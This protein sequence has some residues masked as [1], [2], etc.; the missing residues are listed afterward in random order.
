MRM[1]LLQPL[2]GRLRQE[3]PFLSHPERI[4]GRDR[5]S[6]IDST[7][8][9]TILD[10]D[11]APESRIE[12]GAGV[13][14][15]RGVE[16]T[17][18]GG[19]TIAIDDDTSLQDGSIVAGHVQIGAH[20]LFGK[21]VFVA[22]RGHNYRHR[23]EWLIRDQD[24]DAL[25]RIPPADELGRAQVVIEDDCWIAQAVVISPG[26]YIGRGAVIGANCVV[27]SDVGPYQVHGGV[28]NRKIGT[29]LDFA[30]PFAIDACD[31]AAIPYFYRGF[32]LSQAALRESRRA[33]VVAAREKACL[34]LANAHAGT[35]RV[36]GI[37]NDAGG[38]LGLAV[39]IN[40]VDRGRHHVPPGRFALEMPL[41]SQPS[42]T[43]PSPLKS[44]T[45]VEITAEAPKP[46]WG[47]ASA[48][49]T[50]ST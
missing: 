38:D 48:A 11:A 31:D 33:A 10:A 30:P 28:P 1:N 7:A 35:L 27:T 15:G 13:Y 12:L 19:G 23:P 2:M 36:N 21:Y 41:P 26:R 3:G 43:A 24:M 50:V 32:H 39:A 18:C 29:R 37:Q 42:S 16:L 6:A 25:A 45:W 9:L 44:F 34:V 20:C 17:A 8:R 46:R 40:G 47:I 5:V 22:S 49:L 14:L 4:F